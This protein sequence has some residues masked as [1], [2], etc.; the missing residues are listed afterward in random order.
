[1]ENASRSTGTTALG[2]SLEATPNLGHRPEKSG[3]KILFAG[4]SGPV[5]AAVSDLVSETNHELLRVQSVEQTL[6][7][8]S[9]GHIDLILA[10]TS[11][12]GLSAIELCRVLKRSPATQLLPTFVLWA[13]RDP[14]AEV[15]A[16][17]AG[18][19][20]FLPLPLQARIFHAHIN[21]ALRRKALV[22]KLDDPESILFSLAA[23]VEERDGALSKHCERLARIATS[24]GMALQLSASD[25]LAL[26]RGG[27]LH[28]IGKVAIPDS[29][30]FKPSP[31]T[32]EEWR[33]MEC[34]TVKGEQ[35]CKGMKSLRRVLPILRHHHEKW[36]G[37]GYPDRLRGNEI[38]LLARIV[39]LADIY[40]AL[41]SEREYKREHSPAEAVE[42]IQAETRRGW[43]DP[44]LTARFAEM[45]PS[46]VE[47]GEAVAQDASQLSLHALAGKV[48]HEH[49]LSSPF[50]PLPSDRLDVLAG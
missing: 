1:M 35:I 30:L 45:L 20:A 11:V 14:D 27:Y 8:V 21:S 12:D 34:H 13:Q 17:E 10:D 26:Q 2:W 25:I 6:A 7:L 33:I 5:S 46:I 49:R 47:I 37:S 29:V 15:S 23:S 50:R 16:I 42:I 43:R 44:F 3:C 36:D 24:I 22:D 9:S 31:L 19:D 18:A 28:D 40:D 48:N 32:P 38:P 4:Q 39:Q 41:T